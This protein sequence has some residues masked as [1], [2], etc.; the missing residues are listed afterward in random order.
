[1]ASHNEHEKDKLRDALKVQF[2]YK[3]NFHH[4]AS[5]NRVM[6]NKCTDLGEA[7]K[8]LNQFRCNIINKRHSNRQ[9]RSLY[10]IHALQKL[11]RTTTQWLLVIITPVSGLIEG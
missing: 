4:F 2:I 3:V 1:M 6:D 7:S 9:L 8:S 10:M 5:N 11:P